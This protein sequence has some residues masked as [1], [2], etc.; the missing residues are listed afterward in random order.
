VSRTAFKFLG[1]GAVGLHSG[2]A[3]PVP[4]EEGPG[5]W[6]EAKGELLEC[7]NGIHACRVGDLPYWI[8]DELWSIELAGDLVANPLGLVARRGRLVRRFEAWD[9]D[10]AA[11][12]ARDCAERARG[13]ALEVLASAGH[14]APAARIGEADGDE[15]SLAALDAAFAELP[16]FAGRTA[17]YAADVARYAT[18][19]QVEGADWAACAAYADA[20]LAGFVASAGA[21]PHPDREAAYFATRAEQAA[22]LATR[23]GLADPL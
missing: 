14:A 19:A 15:G 13:R 18:S 10:A 2:F 9:P 7:G 3:W 5:P 20:Y 23:L 12:L 4:R 17:G 22:W 8:D 6:V 1:A 21:A 16:G 11:E